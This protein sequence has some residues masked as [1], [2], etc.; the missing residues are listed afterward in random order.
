MIHI[1]DVEALEFQLNHVVEEAG[2]MVASYCDTTAFAT[3][4]AAEDD[5]PVDRKRSLNFEGS[6]GSTGVEDSAVDAAVAS[7]YDYQGTFD[8][9][10]GLQSQEAWPETPGTLKVD[11]SYMGMAPGLDELV[12][13]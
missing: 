1:F 2:A 11:F 5:D 6:A 8:F 12:L 4:S 9:N 7:G 10:S 13:G 3:T